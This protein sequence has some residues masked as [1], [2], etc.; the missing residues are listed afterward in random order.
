MVLL[1]YGVR[2]RVSNE[3][4]AASLNGEFLPPRAIA[5]YFD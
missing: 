2:V 4:V 5:M 1:P 3:R